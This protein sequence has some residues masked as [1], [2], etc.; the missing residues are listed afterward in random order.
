MQKKLLLALF[1][2]VSTPHTASS[3]RAF[4]SGMRVRITLDADQ[5]V[6]AKLVRLA[7]DSVFLSSGDKDAKILGISRNDILLIETS[8]GKNHL[9]AAVGGGVVGILLGG[10][11]GAIVGSNQP[12]PT[13]A[14]E[15][16]LVC[17]PLTGC[18]HSEIVRVCKSNCFR[19][20]PILSSI[21][22]AIYGLTIGSVTGAVIGSER[23]VARP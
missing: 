19:S 17:S 8:A 13:Y 11:A 12:D 18:T 3:Q 15:V 1:L 23:W 7:P 16:R 14:D 20:P 10:I 22:M 5:K 4:Q 9:A 2:A 21:V 6:I